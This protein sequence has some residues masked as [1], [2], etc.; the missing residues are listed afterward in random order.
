MTFS[1]K[2][3]E[4]EHLKHPLQALSPD[5]NASWV[6]NKHQPHRMEN[7][8]NRYSSIRIPGGHFSNALK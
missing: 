6:V 4:E 3:K 7:N 8:K 1:R 2:I 5:L